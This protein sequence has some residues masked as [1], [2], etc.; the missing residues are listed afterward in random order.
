MRFNIDADDGGRI[1]GWIAPE[2]GADCARVVVFVDGRAMCEVEA[3]RFRA[4]VL[5]QGLHETGAVGFAVDAGAA[6]GLERAEDVELVEADSRLT[7]YRRMRAGRDLPQRLYLAD[8][9]AVPQAD[10]AQAAA[11]RFALACF[12]VERL[13]GETLNAVIAS[14]AAR[15]LFVTGRASYAAHAH[16]LEQARFLRVALLRDPVEEL[17]ERLLFFSRLARSDAGRLLPLYATG[18]EPLAAFA[19]DL[20]LDDPKSLLEIFRSTSEELRAAISSPM[21]RM[22]VCA[23]GETPTRNHV[24]QALDTLADME[25]VGVRGRYDAF[26]ALLSQTIGEDPFG[27]QPFSTFDALP[28]VTAALSRIGIVVDLLQHDIS[29]YRFVDGAIAS[30]LSGED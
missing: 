22:L 14:A 20:P 1:S 5:N 29:L 21:V 19:R 7:I 16:A 18:L 10:F 3:D 4:D 17:A 15:S 24:A 13:A 28:A 6:P 25:V 2:R 27:A 26:R 8:G 30:G 23:E 9:C 11:A 12:N